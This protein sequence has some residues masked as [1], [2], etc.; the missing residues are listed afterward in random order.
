M[1]NFNTKIVLGFT[2]LVFGIA[3]SSA[4]LITNAFAQNVSDIGMATNIQYPIKEL[5]D[6]KDKA[7][8]QAFCDKQENT[9][10]CLNFAEKNDLMSQEEVQMAKKFT[11]VRSGPG[12]CKSKNSCETY[13][14]DISNIDECVS[15]AEKNNMMSSKELNEAKKVRDAIKKGI[16]PPACGNKKACDSYCGAPEHM[17]ECTAFAE[18]AGFMS[19]QELQDS[20]KVLAAIKKGVKP[21]A[22]NGKEACDSYCQQDSNIEECIAF[23]EAAGFM[24]SKDVEMMR[25]TKGKGPGG[26]KGKEE[27]DNFCQKEE[28]ISTCTAFGEENGLISKEDA[29]MMR[30]TGGK[31]PGGCKSKEECDTFCNTPENQETCMNF[32]KDNGMMSQKDL[33]KME[34]GRQQMKEAFSNMPSEVS[35][36]LKSAF[37]VEMVEKIKSGAVMPPQEIGEK[38]RTCF[39]NFRPEPP[40]GMTGQQGGTMQPGQEQGQRNFNPAQIQGG[41][42]GC[43]SPE[44]CNAYCATHQEECQKFQSPPMQPDTQNMQS[45]TQGTEGQQIEKQYQQYQQQ[46]TPAGSAPGTSPGTAPQNQPGQFIQTQQGGQYQQQPMMPQGG[47]APPMQ[48]I[49]QQPMQVGPESNMAPPPAPEPAPQ[50]KP[51]PTTLNS[52]NLFSAIIKPFVKIF[53]L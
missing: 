53:G 46:M 11:E 51:A 40:E 25:K 15:F 23:A 43:Q 16:K 49:Q 37:G 12:G 10:K 7:A 30:K 33:Q 5:G 2:I 38:M 44:E 22:C 50:P 13:C 48:Q 47:Q 27:C 21:P 8:C 41:P 4:I 28:N 34:R 17:E 31:G 29:A 14:N 9:E 20:K 52:N 36:C 1:F 3:V 32:A 39:E 42:G 18:A 6:C 45:G 26:C 24:S 19:S 35:E